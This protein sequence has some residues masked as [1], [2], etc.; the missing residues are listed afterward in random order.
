MAVCLKNEGLLIAW[1]EEKDILF[2]LNAREAKTIIGYLDGC[3]YSLVSE[4]E[5]LYLVDNVEE[6]REDT[7]IDDA[8]DRACE[9]NYELIE[10]TAAEIAAADVDED[11]TDREQYLS[12]LVQD[13]KI[14]NGVFERTQYQKKI[15]KTVNLMTEE[16]APIPVGM[17]R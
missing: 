14:L 4:E 2:R 16:K 7:T 10:E 5:R 15:T 3:G 8:V 12:K 17:S 1:L 13:E 6:S 11:I 9:S